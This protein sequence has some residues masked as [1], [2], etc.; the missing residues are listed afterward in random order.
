MDKG[1]ITMTEKQLRRYQVIQAVIDG[2]VTVNE[3]ANALGLSTRQILRLKKGVKLGGASAVIHGNTNR[4]PANAISAGN[5]AKILEIWNGDAFSS[6]N[7]N[8]FRDILDEHYGITV[9]YSTLHNLMAAEGVKSPKKKRRKKVHRRRAR[10]HQAGLLVQV[11]ATPYQWFYGNSNYYALHGSIDDATGQILS[12]YMTKNECLKGYFKMLERMVENYGIPVSLY[13]DRHTIFQS[14]NKDKAEFD[15]SISVNDTQLGRAL[16]EL[17]VELIP[18]RSPQAKGRIERLWNTLQSRLPVEF[19][20]HNITTVDAA[21]E[22]LSKYIYQYNSQFAV[23]PK[24]SDSAFIR[25]ESLDNL[26]HILCVKETRTVDA[27]GVFSY[28]GKSFVVS[29]DGLNAGIYKG[30]KIDVLV[31]DSYGVAVGFKGKVFSVMPYVPPKRVPKK[32]SDPKPKGHKPSASH[33]WLQ[34]QEMLFSEEYSYPAIM[35]MLTE[36]LEAPY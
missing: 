32:A 3:A 12:L 24:D 19:A 7:F 26:N 28:K 8:H 9:S 31:H 16:K 21:N 17:G 22:F 36:I 2:N 34:E 18:A 1:K 15:S 29:S 27:G 4:T 5:K 25:P 10:R 13:A 11:D 14:P 23:E 6:C 30:T 20:L 33:P 35:E